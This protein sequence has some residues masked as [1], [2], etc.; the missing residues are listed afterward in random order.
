MMLSIRN[1]SSLNR[2]IRCM[3]EAR[4]YVETKGF[5]NLSEKPIRTSTVGEVKAVEGITDF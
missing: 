1:R 2:N 4:G 5:K 3:S